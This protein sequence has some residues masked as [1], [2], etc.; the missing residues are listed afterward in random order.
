MAFSRKGELISAP[1]PAF[2]FF[3]IDID[4]E[5]NQDHH[6]VYCTQTTGG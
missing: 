1:L 5:C 3:F 6:T 4:F 2:I